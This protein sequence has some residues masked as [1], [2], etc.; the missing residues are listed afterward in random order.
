MIF[1]EFT[2]ELYQP[3]IEFVV[4][5]ISLLYSIIFSTSMMANQCFI[6]KHYNCTLNF[7]N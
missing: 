5:K 3:E 2:S 1:K 6:M 7:Y 4:L